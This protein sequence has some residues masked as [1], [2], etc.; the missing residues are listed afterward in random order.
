MTEVL[1]AQKPNFAKCEKAARKLLLKQNS[2]A[3]PVDIQKLRFDV[4]VCFDTF[5]NYSAITGIPVSLLLPSEAFRDGYTVKSEKGFLVLTDVLLSREVGVHRS[6]NVSGNVSGNIHQKR[7]N[8]TL[9]HEVGHITLE[10]ESDGEV[11]EYEADLFAGELLMPEPVLLELERIGGGLN[12]I[13]ISRIFGVS[14]SAAA[15]KLA[16]MRRKQFY[17]VCLHR[18]ILE[19]YRVLIDGYVRGKPAR[20]RS[21]LL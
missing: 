4:D 19:K 5:Q 3:L 11:Q 13:E 16:R 21:V 1:K 14:E 9:A 18:D 10:H 20:K 8:W 15:S 12:E 7:L 2:A 17:S 6:L